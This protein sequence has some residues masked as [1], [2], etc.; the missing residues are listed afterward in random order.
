MWGVPVPTAVLRHALVR[1]MLVPLGPR[2]LC[3]KQ[4][5]FPLTRHR[6]LLCALAGA[7]TSVGAYYT[8]IN[9]A[10]RA[11]LAGKVGLGA[12]HQKHCL[13]AWMACACRCARPDLE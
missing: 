5:L 6:P 7:F 10:S 4:S 12:L 9:Q 13:C 1:R 2:P 11:L 3:D 8:W